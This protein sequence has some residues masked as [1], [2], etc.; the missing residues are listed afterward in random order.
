MT[1]PAIW[2]GSLSDY[3]DGRLHGRW[4]D[5]ST[6][7]LDTVHAEVQDILRTS[8]VPR[9]EEFA[10]FDYE[11]FPTP[12]DEYDSIERVVAIAEAVTAIEPGYAE[13]FAAFISS[14]LAGEDP[15]DWDSE[16]HDA[17]YGEFDSLA[18]FAET[19]AEETGV[20]DDDH[21]LAAYID[22]AAYGRDLATE[23]SVVDV[24]GGIAV[25]SY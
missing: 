23:F 4:I 24:P 5:L 3:N 11:G 6:P 10:I 22:W 20:V 14:G 7:D 9:A 16:F 17:Y 15:A 19:I 25:F 21:P 2:V 1:D 12:I 8:R 18:E 13:A